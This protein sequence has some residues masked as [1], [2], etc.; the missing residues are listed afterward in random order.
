M[1][2]GCSELFFLS[3]QCLG[4]WINAE[5]EVVVTVAKDQPADQ[6]DVLRVS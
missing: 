4:R 1:S 2:S 5:D 3:K 6:A